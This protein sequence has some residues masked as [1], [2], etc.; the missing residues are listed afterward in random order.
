M[1]LEMLAGMLYLVF[2]IKFNCTNVKNKIHVESNYYSRTC[3][4][5]LNIYLGQE[6]SEDFFLELNK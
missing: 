6:W 4:I 1:N 2:Q 3:E 5:K